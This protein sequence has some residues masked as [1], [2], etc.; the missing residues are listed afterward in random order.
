M[1]TVCHIVFLVFNTKRMKLL[2]NQKCLFYINRT[3]H[4]LRH[5][6]QFHI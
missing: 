2:L 1:L 6:T 3:M 5:L 4:F